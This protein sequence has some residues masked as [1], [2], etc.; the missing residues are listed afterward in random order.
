M[1][2][3]HI[4]DV[5]GV[6]VGAAVRIDRGYRFIATD[7]RMEEIDSTI[8]PTLDDVRRVARRAYQNATSAG[9][10]APTLHARAHPPATKER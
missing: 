2:Q 9:P 8:W 5:D 1:L 7:F 6:F 3:S 4:V 10:V